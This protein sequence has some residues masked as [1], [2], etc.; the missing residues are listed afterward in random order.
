MSLH[1]QTEQPPAESTARLIV[2]GVGLLVLAWTTPAVR[3][4][5][6]KFG[7]YSVR[8]KTL[9]QSRVSTDKSAKDNSV[10]TNAALELSAQVRSPKWSK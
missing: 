4:C 1:K 2:L 3:E 6:A 10:M 5:A 7:S 9:A 8:V